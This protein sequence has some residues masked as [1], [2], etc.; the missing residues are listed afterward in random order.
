MRNK[1]LLVVAAAVS[2]ALAGCGG[3][4]SSSSAGG[5]EL[6]KY[7]PARISL[8]GGGQIT[9]KTQGI[10]IRC[11]I[12]KEGEG[13]EVESLL[14]S[15]DGNP[16]KAGQGAGCGIVIPSATVSNYLTANLMEIG[17]CDGTIQTHAMD[18]SNPKKLFVGEGTITTP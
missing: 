6:A 12:D 18:F 2:L 8:L 7:K 3:S 9:C 10:A 16:P 17:Y 14:F 4:S 5:V 1:I 15:V 11:N 13:Y